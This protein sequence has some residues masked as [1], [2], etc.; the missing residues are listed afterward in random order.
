MPQGAPGVG[1]AAVDARFCYGREFGG[2]LA[3]CLLSTAQN[4]F[5]SRA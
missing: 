5:L 4:R 1:R 3:R 2:L